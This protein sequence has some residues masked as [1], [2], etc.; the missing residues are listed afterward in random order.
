MGGKRSGR[1]VGGM[2]RGRRRITRGGGRYGRVD[3]GRR[4][5]PL[6]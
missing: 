3:G 2:V 1:M 4:E 6:S 5:L